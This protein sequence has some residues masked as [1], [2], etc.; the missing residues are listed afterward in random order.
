MK[1]RAGI[2]YDIHRLE[3][4][5][6]LFLGGVEIPYAKGLTGHSDGDCLLH[7]V[8]DALLGAMGERDIGQL[9]P[10]Y[11]PA[12]KDIRSTE[13]LM[14]VMERL[15]RMDFTIINIDCIIIAQEPKLGPFIPAMQKLLCPLLDI[16]PSALSIKA[17]T[18]EGLGELGRSEAVASWATV[19]LQQKESDPRGGQ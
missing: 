19:L 9:F 15:R 2:G 16:D 3:P 7:A 5:R 11:D 10:D 14:Q 1:I 17:K 4:G 12:Y 6:K 13:L 18:N 8:I